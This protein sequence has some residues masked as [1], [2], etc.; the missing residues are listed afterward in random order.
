MAQKNFEI[1]RYSCTFLD[2]LA[3][4]FRTQIGHL[5]ILHPL[6]HHTLISSKPTRASLSIDY[7]P[8]DICQM[9]YFDQPLSC[10]IPRY[11]I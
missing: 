10:D 4:I 5:F 11:L 2:Y 3:Q 6:T 7:Y 8:I 9:Q 1:T